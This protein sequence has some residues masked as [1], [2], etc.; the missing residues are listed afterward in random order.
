M[1]V[2]IAKIIQWKELVH[3][4]KV[5]NNGICVVEEMEEPIDRNQNVFVNA[6][7]HTNIDSGQ[8]ESVVDLHKKERM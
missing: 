6:E 2:M 4:L 5:V 3:D 1:L 8:S 7:I